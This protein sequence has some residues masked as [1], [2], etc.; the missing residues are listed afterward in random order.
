MDYM[1]GA[2]IKDVPVRM[3]AADTTELV[4]E[5]Q[6][7]H[8]TLPTA[9]AAFG[10]TLTATALM[11]MLLKNENNKISVQ[12]KCDGPIEDLLVI[13]NTNGEIKGDIYNPHVHIPLNQIGKLDVAGAIGKGTL[14]IIQDLGLKEPYVGTVELVSGEIGEDFSYYFSVSEQIPSVVALGVLVNPDGTIKKAGGYL[15]QLLP[16]HSEELI[17]Y[18][19][20]R[21]GE[22]PTISKLL[23]EGHEPKEILE[24][25]FKDYKVT[26]TEKKKPVYHCDC[27]RDR[28]ERGLISL[29][30]EEL[31]AIVE[32]DGQAEILCHFCNKKYEFEKADL[33]TLLESIEAK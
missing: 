8:S 4:G 19:E 12:I 1:I 2:M 31:T 23:D 18:I 5:A 32:E 28:F 29:G 7:I 33:I 13:G 6:K 16:N 10:R 21:I 30:R 3:F 17:D 15:I 9:S 24:L 26:F 22:I 27:N 11:T 25:I 14:T 20:K